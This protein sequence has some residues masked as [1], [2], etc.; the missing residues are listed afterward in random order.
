MAG[1][2]V[3]WALHKLP[4][5]GVAQIL[6]ELLDAGIVDANDRALFPFLSGRNP[7]AGAVPVG[8]VRP[9]TLS[10]GAAAAPE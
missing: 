9:P 10:G 1:E 4:D 7:D 8:G 6:H 2:V 3:L 5:G